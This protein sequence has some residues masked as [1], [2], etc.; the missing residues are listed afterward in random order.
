MELEDHMPEAEVA[1][2]LAFHLLDHSKSHGAADV[3]ID[4]AQVRVGKK[5]IFPIL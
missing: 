5:T 1:L 4:G 3:A 2:L